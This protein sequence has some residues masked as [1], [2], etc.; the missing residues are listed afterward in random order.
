MA[1]NFNYPKNQHYVPKLLLKNFTTGKG[2]LIFA[3]DKHREVSF[4]TNIRNI[5][6]EQ[7][8]YD[9]NVNSSIYTFEPSLGSFETKAG[10][11]IKQILKDQSLISLSPEKKTEL[12]EFIAVQLVRVNRIRQTIAE[13]NNCVEEEL[14]RLGI[15]PAHVDGFDY[16][17]EDDCKTTALE[18]LQ[19]YHDYVPYINDKAWML[20]KTSRSRPFC[21]SDNPVVLNNMTDWRP[22]GSLGLAVT[23]IEI[24]LPIS[25]IFML[26]LFC[27]S[28][29]QT[30]LSAYKTGETLKSI[31]FDPAPPD[32]AARVRALANGLQTGTAVSSAQENVVHLN[33]LQ[34][35]Q[36][37][38]YVFS[39]KDDFTLAREMIDGD[40]II[41]R[42]MHFR[43]S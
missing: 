4:K 34:V 39:S 1:D 18:M 21:T 37:S 22:R 23:G 25:N 40:P 13:I 26:A 17:S 19:E 9:I 38:R 29:E 36:S 16:M 42:G 15:D 32:K 31:G 24:Y 35:A 3:F 2:D 11:I 5:A 12:S 6:S 41:K 7:G 27:R 20:F 33:S 14:L 8:F 30:I 43:G 28:L 10:K